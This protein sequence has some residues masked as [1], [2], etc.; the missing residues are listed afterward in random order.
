MPGKGTGMFVDVGEEGTGKRSS[1]DIV[2]VIGEDK[3][4]VLS[5]TS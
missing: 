4:K 3:L 1:E 5:K 2:L